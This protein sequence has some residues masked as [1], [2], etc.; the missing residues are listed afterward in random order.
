MGT[1]DCG[2]CVGKGLAASWNVVDSHVEGC[3]V[4]GVWRESYWGQE[5]IYWM[6]AAWSLSPGIGP[7]REKKSSGAPPAARYVRLARLIE[8]VA[9]DKIH[10]VNYCADAHFIQFYQVVTAEGYE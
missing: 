8:G 4:A 2:Y 1:P 6:Q 10:Y 3:L 5:Y 7:R 9:S